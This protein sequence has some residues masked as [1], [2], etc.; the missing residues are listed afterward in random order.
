MKPLNMKNGTNNIAPIISAA[1][2]LLIN[3]IEINIA[4]LW[5][6][7]DVTIIKPIYAKNR[8][9]PGGCSTRNQVNIPYRT[10]NS[11]VGGISERDF[12]T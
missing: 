3:Q 7:N 5:D 10:G 9:I 6:N 4:K 1:I 8:H 11:N 2:V 12:D